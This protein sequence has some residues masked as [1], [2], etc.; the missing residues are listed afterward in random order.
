VE[1]DLASLLSD[2]A[3]VLIPTSANF[4]RRKIQHLPGVTF[5]YLG[6]RVDLLGM[7]QPRTN[8]LLILSPVSMVGL[9][10]G[11]RVV[12][13]SADMSLVPSSASRLQL[14]SAGKLVSIRLDSRLE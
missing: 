6:D 7:E 9:C 1:A 10:Q 11:L 14:G 5:R 3:V 2:G 8:G 4:L 13:P 12:R